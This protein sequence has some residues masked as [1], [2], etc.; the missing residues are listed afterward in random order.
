MANNENTAPVKESTWDSFLNTW[1]VSEWSN[2]YGDFF[3]ETSDG[4]ISIWPR[5]QKSWIEVWTTIL[6]YIVPIALFLTVLLSGHVFL[7]NQESSWFAE[8]YQFLCGYLNYGIDLEDKWCKTL[9]MLETEYN[10]KSK[11]LQVEIIK[12]LTEYIPIKVS[13]NIMDASP[14]RKFIIDTFNN[15]IPVDEIIKKFDEEINNAQYIGGANAECNGISITNQ[16]FLSTQCV[17]YGSWIGAD[18]SNRKLGSARIEAMRFLEKIGTTAKSQFILLNPPTSLS[19]EPLQIWTN[20]NPNFKTR[21][22]IPL[23]LQYIPL[24]Q[25]L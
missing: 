12:Y 6:G 7:R 10:K 15:K 21:T 1:W 22:A 4:S 14:E 2:I 19:T 25:K 3:Q 24:N 8:N 5:A 23:Q 17:I 13:Q 11:D 16:T 20:L 18:D 9:G